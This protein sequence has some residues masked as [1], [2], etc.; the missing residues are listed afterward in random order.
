MQTLAQLEAKL[1]DVQAK[2]RR[3]DGH[4]EGGYGFNPYRDQEAEIVSQITAIKL[5]ARE[6]HIDENYSE[7]KK[8]W[9][10][11]IIEV[12]KGASGVT[13]AQL[14]EVEKIAGVTLAEVK[15]AKARND[16]ADAGISGKHFE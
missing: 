6:A 11:A 1:E 4:N 2:A 10:L 7:Y 14:A 5:A 15:A 8:R 9:S 13:P 16:G 12:A 3:H